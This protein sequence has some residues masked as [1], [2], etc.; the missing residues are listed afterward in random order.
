MARVSLTPQKV[1]PAGLQPTMTAPN[2]DGDIIPADGRSVL[3]VTNA[4]GAPINVT[5]QTP[6]QVDGLDV[7]ELIVAVA[8]GAVCKLIG[9]FSAATFGRPDGGADADMVYVN[10]SSQASITRGLISL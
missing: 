10:Y 3:V 9:P 1:V 7:S 4:A 5:A 8:N 6:R 2:A